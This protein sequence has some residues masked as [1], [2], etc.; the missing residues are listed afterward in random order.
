MTSKIKWLL[1]STFGL[2]LI[3]TGLS[4]AID[5]GF[6][7]YANH[8]WVLYGTMAL[9]VFNSGICILIDAGLKNSSSKKK[10]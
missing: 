4:M 6:E 8:P 2:L 9:V 5:A 10:S 7:K 3:G 1:Q